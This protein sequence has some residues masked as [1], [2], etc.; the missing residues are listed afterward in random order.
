MFLLLLDLQIYLDNIHVNE[1]SQDDWRHP[2]FHNGR[3][4]QNMKLPLSNFGPCSWRTNLM[5]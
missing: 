4:L 1:E 5:R 2:D 3:T